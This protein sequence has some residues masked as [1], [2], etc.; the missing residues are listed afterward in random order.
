MKNIDVKTC[1]VC[2]FEKSIDIFII[3]IEN[4]YSV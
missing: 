1:V 3:K 2:H 4:V